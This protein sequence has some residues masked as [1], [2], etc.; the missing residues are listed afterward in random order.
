MNE[1]RRVVNAIVARHGA[2]AEIVVETL[3]DLGRS[4]KQ[5]EEYTRDQKNNRDAND[6][7]KGKLA[8]MSLKVNASNMMRLRLLE[9]Q[10]RDPKNRMCPYT[11]TLITPR[12]ALSEAIEEDHLLPFAAALDDSSAN[13]IL[14]TR[15]ANRV[16]AKRTP[17]DAFGHSKEWPAILERAAL[18]P[19]NKRWR[20]E[21]DALAK[22]A[23]EGDFLARHLTDSATIARW[24][25]EYLEV[26]V[27]GHVWSI[28]GRLTA[29]LRHALGLNSRSVLGK[30]GAMKDRKDHRHHAI[31]AVVVGLT[32]RGMLHRVTRAAKAAEGSGERLVVALEAP[33]V[34]FVL[35]WR[36]GCTRLW[37]RTSRIRDGKR[38][39]ITTPRMGRSR[40]RRRRSP[41]WW[42]G[43]RFLRSR[44]G[45]PM[46]HGWGCAMRCWG[47][48]WQ[49][50]WRWA[51]PRRARRHWRR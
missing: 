4:K 29:L 38:R 19:G 8:E 31:D 18:L 33:W 6:A 25:V 32:D 46:M 15:E 39:C 50:Y 41:T 35:R 20:F 5:R 27:P 43:G 49:R 51:T 37:F 24:A 45:R 7:R 30:G 22:Y 11:G 34:G 13:R 40:A 3:R 48:R 42:C 23:R 47:R 26:L 17:Y 1:I 9:E 14:V 36:H 2:P 16:K 12:M 10:A 28:P 21:P 44:T